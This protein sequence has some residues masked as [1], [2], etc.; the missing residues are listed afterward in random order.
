MKDLLFAGSWNKAPKEFQCSWKFN[1]EEPEIKGDKN[2][3]E[4]HAGKI[5]DFPQC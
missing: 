1:T 5:K 3:S 4:K 2:C